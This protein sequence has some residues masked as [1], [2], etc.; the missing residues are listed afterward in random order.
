MAL[1]FVLVLLL[2]YVRCGD[3]HIQYGYALSIYPVSVGCRHL[4]SVPDSYLDGCVHARATATGQARG[5]Q[6]SGVRSSPAE[7]NTVVR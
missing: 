4:A 1:P 7:R 6:E 3:R 5:T 2:Q